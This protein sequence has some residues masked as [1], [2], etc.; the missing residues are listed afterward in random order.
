VDTVAAEAGTD[1]ATYYQAFGSKEKLVEALLGRIES[2][3]LEAG[4]ADPNRLAHQL[5]LLIDGAI[6]VAMISRD[7]GAAQRTTEAADSLFAPLDRGA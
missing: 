6:F 7:P 5:G 1:K 3:A 2:L 4:A